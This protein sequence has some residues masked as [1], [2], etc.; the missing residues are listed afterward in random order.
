MGDSGVVYGWTCAFCGVYVP[1]G[2]EHSHAPLTNS[3]LPIVDAIEV[4]FKAKDDRIA[5]LTQRNAELE[6]E[7]ER[8][9]AALTDIA[10]GRWNVAKP[11][12]FKS[13]PQFARMALDA[14]REGAE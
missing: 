2:V 1:G 14:A 6:A 3:F 12:S 11:W 8:L 5:A 7:V 4:P 10:V 9:K 13:A